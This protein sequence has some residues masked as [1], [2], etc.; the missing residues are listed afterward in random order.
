[1]A[2]VMRMTVR[3]SG[4]FSHRDTVGCEQRSVPLGQP[5]AGQLEAGIDA[6]M[7]EVVGILV[8]ASDGED[9]GAQDVGDA[10][11]DQQRIALVLD[12]PGEPVRKT[13]V[14]IAM[15]LSSRTPPSEVRRPPSNAAVTFLR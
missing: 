4:A 7:V 14:S 8:A 13:H 15:L 5:P 9:A 1:M 12:Q 2:W 3:R 10:V 6:Q 11:R